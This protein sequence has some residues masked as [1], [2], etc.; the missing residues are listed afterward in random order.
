MLKHPQLTL[1]RLERCLNHEIRPRLYQERTPL[2]VA[3]YQGQDPIPHA[4]AVRREFRPVPLGF[5]WGPAW[6]TAWFRLRGTIPAAFAGKEVVAL[7]DTASEALVWDGDSPGQG[8]DTNRDDYLLTESAAGGE[9]VELYVEAAGNH[10]FGI[11]A[12]GAQD[13]LARIPEPFELRQAHLAWRDR[14]YWDLYHDF[15]VLLDLLKA[16]P[17]SDPRRAQLLYT[18][19]EST[20]RLLTGEGPVSARQVLAPALA[21][22]ARASAHQVSAIGHSHIDV[23]WRWPLRE[24][25]RKCSRTFSTVLRYMERYP[26]YKFGQSQPQLYAFTKEHYPKLYERI[27][28]A[29]AAGRWEPVGAMWVEADCNLSSGESLVRQV[30]H[31]K[32]FFMEEFGVETDVLYLPDVF[33]YSAALPQILKKARV[34]YF[35]TQKISWNQFNRFPHHTF[36]W[37]GID[38]TRVFSHFLPADT[39]NSLYTPSE[40][41]LGESR[42]LDSDRAHRWL[43]L[44]GYG[45]GGGGPTQEMLEAAKRLKDLD[46]VPRVEQ[47]FARDFFHK[48]EAEAKDLPVWVGELYLELHR[49]TYTTQA[50]NKKMNRRCELLLRDAEFFASLRPGAFQNY[51]AAALDRCWKL[52]L[53]NQFHDVIPGSSI[54]WVYEDSRRQYAEVEQTAE[55]IIGDALTEL[56]AEVD[57]SGRDQPVIVWNSLS[58]AHYGTVQVPVGDQTPQSVVDPDGFRFPVQIVTEEGQRYALFVGEAPPYGYAVYNFSDQPVEDVPRTGVTGTERSLENGLLRVELDDRGLLTSVLDKRYDRQVLVP[59]QPANV[60]QLFDDRPNNW[61]AWDIDA[62]YAETG[63][64]LTEVESIRVVET[65]PVRGAIEVVRRFGNSLVRQTIRLV[66]HSTR[67]DFVT[68]V[69]WHEQSKLLKVAFPVQI[70]ANQASFEIQYGHVQR[71][72]HRNTSWDLARFE[73]VGHKWADLCEGDYGVALLNDCK[74]GHDVQGNTLRLSLLRA[75]NEP[76]PNADRGQHRFTYAL[77]PHR[78]GVRFGGVV[79]E[80]YRL[81]VP[82]R[83]TPVTSHPGQRPPEHSFFTLDSGDVFLEVIKRAEKEDAL[84]LRLYEGH[85]TRGTVTLTTSLPVRQAF[86]TDLMEDPIQELPVEEGKIRIPVNPFEIVTLLLRG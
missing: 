11:S 82:L 8:L 55:Q 65:G 85:N 49:G 61:D 81:N 73:V 14:D 68:E 57:T 1:Q 44:F 40:L 46:G 35:M 69:D 59:G 54:G 12:M 86:L 9:P 7:I 20:N 83:A 13:G 23:A 36:L 53:L 19:N 31:G 66:A 16:L 17:E 15:R 71:P 4:E 18:L 75:P 45:D 70:N 41:R 28:Q 74:Y 50:Y 79:A 2:E 56:A 42:F 32:R 62:F 21:L 80:A 84:V 43:Y 34:N 39:Y 30:L 78:G 27:K 26:D 63:R 67:I 51:P 25:I 48:A 58:R 6:S 5:R 76:D 72:T 77:Y 3:V 60:L 47:E 29:V 38:G 22:P 24:T 52:V 10:L 64:D 33:G 37:Q